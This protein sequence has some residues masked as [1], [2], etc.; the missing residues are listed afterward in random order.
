MKPC[1][2]LIASCVAFVAFTA[3]NRIALAQDRNASIALK[4]VEPSDGTHFRSGIA[5]QLRASLTETGGTWRVEFFDDVQRIGETVPDRPFW[6]ND[7]CGGRHAITAR[8][9]DTLIFIVPC[10]TPN[11]RHK[12]IQQ[13]HRFD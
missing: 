10:S 6:W 13:R 8:A 3:P 2:F 11:S 9:A 1:V 4:L 5:I 12:P 7:A